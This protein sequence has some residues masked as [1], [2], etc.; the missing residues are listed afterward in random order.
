MPR[1]RRPYRQIE[2]RYIV[3]YVL[4]R[5]PDAIYRAFN[6]RLGIPKPIERSIVAMT[7]Y[8]IAKLWAPTADA[9]VITKNYVL[10]IEA[11]IRYP[12]QGVGQLKDYVRRVCNTPGLSHYC[13]NRRVLGVLVVPLYDPDIARLCQEEGIIYH[14]FTPCWVLDYMVEVQILPATVAEE[15]KRRGKCI[16]T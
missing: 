4:N 9:V 1:K 14:V 3:E 5:Y 13:P 7:E 6:V 8:N 10:V 12:R 15:L 16:R 11:K 2:R